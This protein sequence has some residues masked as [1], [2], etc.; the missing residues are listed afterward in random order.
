MTHLLPWCVVH[1]RIAHLDEGTTVAEDGSQVA[2]GAANA[3]DADADRLEVGN[4]VVNELALPRQR[5]QVLEAKEKVPAVLVGKVAVDQ[6]LLELPDVEEGCARA[7][8]A[9]RQPMLKG[10]GQGEGRRL[11]KTHDHLAFLDR[12][13][14][15]IQT[16]TA[17][18]T[19][20]PLVLDL[21]LG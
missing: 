13:E 5:A 2:C 10:K 21:V 19:A 9:T 3:V 8:C 1:V 18:A 11:T 4:D 17:R 14:D 12:G 15:S 6:E 16:P 20:S 7:L